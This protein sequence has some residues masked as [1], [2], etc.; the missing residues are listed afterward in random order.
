MTSQAPS[1]SDA[2]WK[3]LEGAYDLHVHVGPDVIPRRIDDSAITTD[4][5]IYAQANGYPSPHKPIGAPPVFFFEPHQPE[6]CQFKPQALL[7]ITSVF[8]RKRQAMECM[9][10]QEHLWNYHTELAK[11][12]GVQAVRNSG[13]KDIVYAEAYERL[14]PQVAGELL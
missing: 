4:A 11:R 1:V 10:A 8:D 5:R 14:Y 12:R 7:D 9:D 13:R 6:M 2:A 3:V